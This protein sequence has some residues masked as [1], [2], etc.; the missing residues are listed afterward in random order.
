MLSQPRSTQAFGAEAFSALFVHL[1]HQCGSKTAPL[2]GRCWSCLRPGPPAR[3]DARDAC[4]QRGS[5]GRGRK[6]PG[7]SQPAGSRHY[8]N[9]GG[10]RKLSRVSRVSGAANGER[11]EAA[12]R[13]GRI[14]SKG[15]AGSKG[16]DVDPNG[17]EFFG[18]F[19]FRR[20]WARRAA[21]IAL[22]NALAK[23]VH[24]SLGSSVDEI[25]FT[26]VPS[27]TRRRRAPSAQ[28]NPWDVS[29]VQNL[30]FGWPG[31]F[32]SHFASQNTG[33]SH[34]HSYPKP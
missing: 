28:C 3:R 1:R 27:D 32:A 29:I 18:F 14:N 34:L 7:G 30:S 25:H 33:V 11:W 4:G 24:C 6:L 20:R 16:R 22:N 10:G 26:K 31:A 15:P 19:G 21:H 23:I 13:L 8:Q 9:P 17:A 12:G 2:R 5:A